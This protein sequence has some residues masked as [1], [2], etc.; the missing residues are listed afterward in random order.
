MTGG[1]DFGRYLDWDLEKLLEQLAR[2]QSTIADAFDQLGE[3]R[4]ME[5]QEQAAGWAHSG[6]TTVRAREKSSSYASVG[7]TQ[8]KYETLA[9]VDAAREER[10]FLVTLIGVRRD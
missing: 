2:V 7:S 4:S 1:H 8:V 10:D 6:E 5:L 3:A 9:I